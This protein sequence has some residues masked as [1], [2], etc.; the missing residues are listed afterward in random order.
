MLD[1]EVAAS[2]AFQ[3]FND[4]VIGTMGDFGVSHPLHASTGESEPTRSRKVCR[5]DT[6]K[7]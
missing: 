2:S 1:F 5:G 3:F 7:V 4:Q 6:T